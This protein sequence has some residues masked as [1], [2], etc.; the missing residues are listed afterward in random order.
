M[1]RIRKALAPISSNITPNHELSP[2]QRGLIIGAASNGTKIKDIAAST[3]R[4]PSTVISTLKKVAQ[5]IEGKSKP[6]SGRPK[7]YSARIERAVI[8]HAHLHPK[9]TYEQLR[10]AIGSKI[11]NRT[12]LRILKGCGIGNW[13]AARRPELTQ[14]AADERL[15]WCRCRA[16]WDWE[17]WSKYMWSDKCSLKRSSGKKQEWCFRTPKQKYNPRM[18]M[19]YGK[20]HD[21]KTMVWGCFWGSGRSELYIMDRDFESKK[22]GYSAN[23]Y[24][25]VLDAQVAKHHTDDLIFMQDNAPIHIARKVTDWFVEQSVRRTDWPPY[26]PDLNPIE[27]LW[28]ALKKKV[29][30]DYPHLL[31]GGKGEE[32]IQALKK[33]CKEAWDNLPKSLLDSLIRSMPRRVEACIAAEGW[34]TKY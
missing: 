32:D 11:S 6:R 18:V 20:G 13:K 12:I 24:I 23:S 21:I 5:R 1:L 34:H 17:R 16:H 30:E 19:T 4:T 15:L 25:E 27:H 9:A 33:A 7:K 8:H 29:F 28:W 3:K 22:N 10:H 26:S 2:Y 31:D 14:E